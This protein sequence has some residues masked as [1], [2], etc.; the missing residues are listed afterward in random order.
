MECWRGYEKKDRNG[1]A[2]GLE[3]DIGMLVQFRDFFFKMFDGMRLYIVGVF[4]FCL[5]VFVCWISGVGIFSQAI[6]GGRVCEVGFVFVVFVVFGFCFVVE[7]NVSGCIF[8][9]VFV[10]LS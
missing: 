1:P 2:V 4:G 10:C 6:F 5:L 8:P 3:S 9:V 7:K